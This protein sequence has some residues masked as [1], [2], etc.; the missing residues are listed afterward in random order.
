MLIER[1]YQ[2]DYL[3]LCLWESYT[4]VV[5]DVGTSEYVRHYQ[6][7]SLSLSLG[8]LHYRGT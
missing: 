1:H 8:E 7:D 5:L 4:I 6:L 2:L 3:Y